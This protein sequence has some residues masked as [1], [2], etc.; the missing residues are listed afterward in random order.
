MPTAFGT[1]GENCL[2][3]PQ[4]NYWGTCPGCNASGIPSAAKFTTTDNRAG[5]AKIKTKG[6]TAKYTHDLAGTTFTAIGDYSTLTKHYQEDS[7]R[8]AVH[9]LPVLQRQRRQPELARTA[10]ERRR[11][12]AELDRR[13]YTACTSTASTTTAGK[14][15]RS[16]APR[17]STSPGN[18]KRRLQRI[19]RFRPAPWP[20]SLHAVS[21]R[22]AVALGTSTVPLALADPNG[23][24]PATKAPYS[25]TTKSY[26]IF[27][28]IEYRF[29]DLIGL[30]LGARY[31]QRPRR[32]TASAGIRTNTT[33]RAPTGR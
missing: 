32:T 9:D 3:G 13:A 6:L 19:F 24:L 22:L 26:A 30:T 18:P 4:D 2:V 8:H 16:S 21:D 31:H 27:G 17:S 14:G 33:R 25:L 11:Q 12:E 29:T 15:R 23:G 20:Y 28:Q 1:N 7:G 10:S 5:F